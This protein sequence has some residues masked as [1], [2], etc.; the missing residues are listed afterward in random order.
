MSLHIHFT[1]TD[2]CGITFATAPDPLWEAL[3]ALH[4]LQAAPSGPATARWQAHVEVSS[5]VR[6]LF[7]LAP[8]RGYSPD[9]LT[10]AQGADGIEAGLDA[11]LA[12]PAT[13]L[14][15]EL[16]LLLGAGQMPH[17]AQELASGDRTTLREVA[18]G[19][20]VFYRK[21]LTPCWA[22]LSERIEDER[23]VRATGMLDTGLDGLLSGL[24]PLLLWRERTLEV[25]GGHVRGDLHLNGRGL[26]LVPSF[27]CHGAPTL[28]ADPSLP[29]VLVYP[30][31]PAP[32]RPPVA[33]PGP[34][35]ALAALLGKTR[36]HLL[37]AAGHSP[38]TTELGRS[39][40]I[41]PASASYHATILR[42]AGLIHTQRAGVAVRHQLTQLGADLI[43]RQP[44]V[45]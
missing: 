41:S 40:G 38:T 19:L 2:L 14:R 36:A 16:E 17:W 15:T 42:N 37:V 12:T 7:A 33:T 31:A 20:R 29:P 13:R 4:A 11:I 44:A 5:P 1:D 30:I 24:H 23:R 6:G 28:L 34:S 3:L 32:D 18:T 8:A 25:H 45:A 26:R 35:E 43:T 27:F 39:A 22:E 10:P 21:A 9:F